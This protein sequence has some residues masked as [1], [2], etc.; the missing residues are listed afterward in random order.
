MTDLTSPAPAG[1]DPVIYRGVADLEAAVGKE[2]GPTGW[3]TVGQERID[4]F[5]DAT[6]DHQW[7]HVD[8]VR[9]VD[10]PFG[11]TVAHGFLTLSL[12]PYFVNCLRRIEDVRMGVNYGLDKVR[13]PAPVRAGSRIRARTTMIRLDRVEGGAVQL[14]TRTTIEVDGD[15]KPACVA[16]LVSRYYFD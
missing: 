5:A 4:G 6:E 10:G 12:V 2:L 16:D 1:V 9:A 13:F 11:A 15:V 7:I 8:P 3:F 14:V